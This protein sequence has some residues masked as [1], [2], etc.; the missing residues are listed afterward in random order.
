MRT[1]I[2]I[3]VNEVLPSRVN[4]LKALGVPPSAPPDVRVNR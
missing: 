3:K 1:K 2:E 4:V